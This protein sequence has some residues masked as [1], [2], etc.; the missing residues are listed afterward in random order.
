MLSKSC[1]SYLAYLIHLLMLSFSTRI[2]FTVLS[3]FF[4]S[5]GS[6]LK[7]MFLNSEYL[8]TCHSTGCLVVDAESR[9]WFCTSFFCQSV[10]YVIIIVAI[11]ETK[12]SQSDNDA[13]ENDMPFPAKSYRKLWTRLIDKLSQRGA[14]KDPAL[15]SPDILYFMEHIGIEKPYRIRFEGTS[16]CDFKMHLYHKIA[17]CG[18]I[19]HIYNVTNSCVNQWWTRQ[20]FVTY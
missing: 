9:Q 14:E 4:L 6:A 7:D 15:P 19:H 12:R 8:T 5:F 3:N 18:I 20:K 13:E 17:N 16:Q 11:S 2:V 1:R 10:L